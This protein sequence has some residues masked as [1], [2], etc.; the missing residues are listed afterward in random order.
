MSAVDPELAEVLA[1]Y[2]FA[3]DIVATAPLKTGHINTT[4][5]V[6]VLVPE[7]RRRVVR[8]RRR[9]RVVARV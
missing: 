7:G 5:V 6:H 2:S 9:G 4:Y 8:A 1:N 3:R